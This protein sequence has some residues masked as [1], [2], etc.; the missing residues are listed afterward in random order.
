MCIFDNWDLG[1]TKTMFVYARRKSNI[2]RQINFGCV[3][4]NRRSSVCLFNHHHQ[5]LNTDVQFV[6]VTQQLNIEQMLISLNWQQGWMDLSMRNLRSDS[7]PMAPNSAESV[8]VGLSC[9]HTP[10]HARVCA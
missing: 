3:K 5:L 6:R 8:P 1:V 9:V 10:T 4:L 2:E 7:F